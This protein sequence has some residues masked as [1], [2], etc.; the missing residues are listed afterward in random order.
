ME[1]RL[2]KRL[3]SISVCVPLSILDR[4]LWS[5]TSPVVGKKFKVKKRFIKL[6][7]LQ[8]ACLLANAKASL[9]IRGGGKEKQSICG[10]TYGIQ[11]FHLE[12]NKHLMQLWRFTNFPS[13][14]VA[15]MFFHNRIIYCLGV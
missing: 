10:A 14:G 13:D 8:A 1:G 3:S 4:A 15:I 11:M 5:F 6:F 7:Y 9:S 12:V 2:T